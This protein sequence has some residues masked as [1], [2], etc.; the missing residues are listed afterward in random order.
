MNKKKKIFF[1][2]PSF[3]VGGIEHQLLQ[4]LK[5]FDKNKY[6]FHL[7]IFFDYRDRPSYHKE[8]PQEVTYTQLDFSGYFD[9]KNLRRLWR[10]LKSEQ[11]DLVVTSTFP[12]NTLLRLFQP[13][14]SY[15]TLPREHNVY[16]DKKRWQWFI[17]RIFSRFSPQIIAVS[18]TVAEFSSRRS[19]IDLKKFTVVNNGVDVERL[20]AYRASNDHVG[21]TIRRDLGIA[22]DERIILNVARLKKQKNHAL[23]LRSFADFRAEFPEYKLVILGDGQ[24]RKNLEKLIHELKLEKSVFLL[25]FR[26]DVWNFYQTADFF[27]LSSER[28]GFPNVVV[29]AMAFGLPVISTVVGGIDEI[30]ENGKNGFIAKNESDFKSALRQ[31]A[32]ANKNEREAMR[33]ECLK[34][35]EHFD[36]RKIVKK[37]EM[38]FD[39]LL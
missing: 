38:L 24:E 39:T 14:F 10:L 22:S 3:C 7:V 21:E 12:A 19:G 1:A 13:F 2:I 34:T 17:D 9:F 4:Q 29:E 32:M 35:A 11:P 30:L 27:A 18:K 8:L 28:E 37:Y 31:V 36:I 20:K 6:Q 33:K 26:T 23:L 16:V 5:H 25:G 15:R